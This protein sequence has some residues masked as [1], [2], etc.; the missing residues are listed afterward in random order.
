MSNLRRNPRAL[1]LAM[2]PGLVL[3]GMF[4]FYPILAA[5][6][7]A[8]YDWS[9][10]NSPRIF[11]GLDNFTRLLSDP[12]F[13]GAF[14]RSL[15]FLLGTVPLQMFISLW[16]AVLLNNQMLK[17]SNVF[18]TLIFLPVVT[19]VAVIGIVWTFLLS[20]FNGPINGLLLDLGLVTRPIDFLGS[21]STVMPSLV[22]VYV[23]KWLGLTMIYWLAALQT[24]PD[25]VYEAAKLD[26][27]KGGRLLL[28]IVFPIIRPF[29]LVIFLISAVG[30]LNVFP[31]IM[32]MTNGGPFFSS[33]VIE[34]FIYRSA[35]ATA[36]GTR[37]QLGYAAA[38]GVLFGLLIMMLTLLQ[39]FISRHSGKSR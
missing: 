19:P 35:F 12:F 25:D 20:P 36:E 34:I 5:G 38:A 13:W 11:V 28:L 27:C 30:A 29:A 18:R 26:N 39:A 4:T 15:I 6:Y 31:L 2:V 33:E 10:F 32:S 14:K 16:L 3:A 8:L 1:Y 22:M 9:G 23:W 37:T 7:Y 17:L 21:S 24:V